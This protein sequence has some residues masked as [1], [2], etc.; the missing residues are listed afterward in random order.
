MTASNKPTRPFD[1]I[2]FDWDGTLV[3]SLAHIVG[4]LSYSINDL[5]L[6]KRT[7]AE[8]RNIIGLGLEEAL[9]ALFPELPLEETLGLA[10]RYRHHYGTTLAQ[11][12]ETFPGVPAMLASLEQQGYL[13]AVATGKS[14][15]GLK[16]SLDDTQ[17]A[18]RFVSTKTADETAGKPNPMMLN[19]L[20][21]EF[22]IA[23]E[24]ALMIGDTTYDLE[25][26]QRA[27]VPAIG[28]THGVHSVAELA[29]F[30]PLVLLDDVAR[31]PEW[32]ASYH[33]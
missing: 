1:L 26:A 17:I 8:L 12:H 18:D 7:D 5:G 33:R 29:A 15:G 23:P 20:L 22:A 32:L 6:P 27:G 31:L 24:R 2:A 4:A 13:L 11:K 16:M 3:D 10:R 19:E 25:M 28:V 21:Q 9:Q 14:R 30:E